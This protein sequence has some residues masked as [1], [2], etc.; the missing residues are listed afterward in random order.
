MEGGRSERL[1]DPAVPGAKASTGSAGP[2]GCPSCVSQGSVRDTRRPGACWRLIGVSHRTLRRRMPSASHARGGYRPGL[3]PNCLVD[4]VGHRPA[5]HRPRRYLRLAPQDFRSPSTSRQPPLCGGTRLSFRRDVTS[6]PAVTALSLNQ[7][8]DHR[9]G[10][11][12]MGQ[13][14]ASSPRAKDRGHLQTAERRCD[15]IS[16]VWRPTPLPIIYLPR[17]GH[18]SPPP[19]TLPPVGDF[20]EKWIWVGIQVK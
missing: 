9:G 11:S 18:P 4:S 13:T 19:S 1:P 3:T 16:A 10:T 6:E 2:S 12:A 5:I 8:T 17:R 15:L 14:V 20:S 7:L